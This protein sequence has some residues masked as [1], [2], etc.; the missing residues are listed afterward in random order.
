LGAFPNL[1]TGEFPF[2]N[3]SERYFKSGRPFLQR[4]LPYWLASFI[5]RRL[6]ILLPFMAVL[7]GVLQALPRMLE[8]RIKKRFV[9]WYRALKALED[10][11]WKTKQ[12]TRQ[13]VSQ[14]R[15]E[16]ESIDAQASQ[17]RVPTR[18]LHDVYALKQAISVVRHRI[19]MAAGGV[20]G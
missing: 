5:E 4:Y 8:S 3:E 16:I 12:P 2:S 17:I 11:I 20:D 1:N 7:I 15:D 9:V 6:L 13:Q 10:E 14:W 19:S 18:Y